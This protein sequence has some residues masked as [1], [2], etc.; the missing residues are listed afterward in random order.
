MSRIFKMENNDRNSSLE[1]NE[2]Q[3]QLVNIL[4]KYGELNREQ[5]VK[6]LKRPRTTIYDNIIILVNRG[7][8]KK[9]PKM[10]NHKGRPI[11]FFKLNQKSENLL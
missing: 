4:E 6:F 8:I 10:I 1:M 3:L 9:F 11:V 2:I 7:L 5:M